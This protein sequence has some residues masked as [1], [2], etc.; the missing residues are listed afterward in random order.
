MSIKRYFMIIMIVFTLT[1][2]SFMLITVS[3]LFDE[4]SWRIL[5]QQKILSIP[6]G[7]FL[8]IV[9]LL[10]AVI[11]GAF[12]GITLVQQ[13]EKIHFTIKKMVSGLPADDN[14]QTIIT[15]QELQR[16]NIQL[17]QLRKTIKRQAEKAQQMTN[18]SREQEEKI[19][20]ATLTKER[21]RLARELHDSVSQQL[22]AASMMLSAVNENK[23]YSAEQARQLQLIEE[24]VVQAQSEMR[25]LLL[26]LRPVQLKGMKLVE[27]VENL[28]AELSAKQPLNIFW[29][30]DDIS[31]KKGVEHHLFRIIQESI[32]NTLRH[33]R[34][35]SLEVYLLKK[36]G[37][38]FLKII[39]DGV[40]FQMNEERFGSYGLK[41]I[42]ERVD[43]IG[44]HLKIISFPNRGTS[45]E[46]KVPILDEGV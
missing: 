3:F 17:K 44:G 34:A 33:A 39:D 43:E 40:G 5:Y 15:F 8:M 28:L 23:T 25:G 35:S 4:F 14:E 16:M 11:T 9:S 19:Q 13:L 22:F 45:I 12:M 46:V 29:K 10:L 38:V 27:G 18:L 20:K 2:I 37:L 21:N 6:S 32:S 42:K 7:I 36:D 24:M 30:I 26:Q 31:L 41:S 1:L